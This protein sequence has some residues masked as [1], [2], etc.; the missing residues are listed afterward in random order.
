MSALKLSRTFTFHCVGDQLSP[1]LRLLWSDSL[2]RSSSGEDPFPVSVFCLPF[3]PASYLETVAVS[4]LGDFGDHERGQM[5]LEGA[6]AFRG[7]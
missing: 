1:R 6:R 4:G 2:S 3:R 7:T 5:L